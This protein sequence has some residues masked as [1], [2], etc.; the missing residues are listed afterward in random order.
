METEPQTAPLTVLSRVLEEFTLIL[1]KHDPM[2]LGSED[3]AEYESEALSVLARFQEAELSVVPEDLAQPAAPRLEMDTLEFWF[4]GDQ[5]GDL[6]VQSLSR[7]LIT[8][9]LTAFNEPVEMAQED[10][11]NESEEEG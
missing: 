6:E 10:E 9:Y 5:V 8:V 1:F 2:S 4:D 7:E 11:T 3:I